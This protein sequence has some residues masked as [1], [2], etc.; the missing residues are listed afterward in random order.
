[1]EA[2]PLARWAAHCGFVSASGLI[3]T[4]PLIRWLTPPT[5]IYRPL[6]LKECYYFVSLRR[7]G[8]GKRIG[9]W[10]GN[11]AFDFANN[12]ERPAPRGWKPTLG[13][14]SSVNRVAL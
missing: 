9:R 3:A 4:M 14:S 12:N 6:A 1:M 8:L 10:L 13:A 2:E 7:A 11:V 5:E